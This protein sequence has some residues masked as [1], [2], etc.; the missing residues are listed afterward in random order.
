MARPAYKPQQHPRSPDPRVPFENLLLVEGAEDFHVF[1]SLLDAH[2]LLIH[3]RMT[4]AEGYENLR[5]TLA[6]RLKESGLQRLAVVV[7]ADEDLTERWTS[8]RKV[9]ISDRGGYDPASVPEVPEPAGTIIRQDG[10]TT[11]GFWIMPNNALKGALE[12]FIRFLVPS[13]DILW[14]YAETCVAG[15]PSVPHANSD[16]WHSKARMHTWLAWQEKPGYPMGKA[17]TA[18]YLDPRVPEAMVLI[19]WLRRLFELE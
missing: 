9:L 5:D 10:K 1:L 13:G 17:I 4:E 11:V 3:C 16:N 7:D 8:L 15:L 19:A 18:R 2:N 14:P 12:E 6:T